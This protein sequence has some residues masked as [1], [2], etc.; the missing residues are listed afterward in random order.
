[1]NSLSF[2]W[3]KFDNCAF[4]Y[5]NK[6][7]L[8]SYYIADNITNLNSFWLFHFLFFYSFQLGGCKCISRIS[9]NRI[10]F[11]IYKW[12]LNINND[13]CDCKPVS[14]DPTTFLCSIVAAIW[15]FKC[16]TLLWWFSLLFYS[17][18]DVRR[19][20]VFLNNTHMFWKLNWTFSYVFCQ[21]FKFFLFTLTNTLNLSKRM[22]IPYWYSW[23]KLS[24]NC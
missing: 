21:I 23:G 4:L 17:F 13:C 2:F 9:R 12:M 5:Q 10:C 18:I 11:G 24:A 14:S 15:I 1:M 6:F 7:L 19:V 20:I 16:K 22:Y 3:I 8:P